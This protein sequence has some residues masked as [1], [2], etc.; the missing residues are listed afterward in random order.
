MSATI[1]VPF[2]LGVTIWRAKYGFRE[3]WVTCP[4]CCGTKAVTL[5]LGNGE[6]YS[7]DCACCQS[8]YGPPLGVV[9]ETVYECDP[10]RF[11]PTK[12]DKWGDEWVYSDGH[13]NVYVKDLFD[14]EDPCRRRCDEM[15]R[16]HEAEL[17]RRNEAIHESKKRDLAWSVHYWGRTVKRLEREL[18]GARAR[19]SRARAGTQK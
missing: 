8:G 11:T 16:E 2:A 10:R 4:E 13:N 15:N 14:A 12:I 6:N 9:K 1:E 18:E 3:T 19:L 7:I 5:I 17:V